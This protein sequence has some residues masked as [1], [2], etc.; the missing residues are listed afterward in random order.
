MAEPTATD[1]Q[2]REALNTGTKPVAESHRFNEAD[3]AAWMSDHV[4]GFAGPLEVRQFKGGQSNPTY[5]LTTPGQK[6]V[7]R[8]K[9]PGKLLPSAH[10]VDREYRVISALHPTGFPVPRPYGLCED[11][12]VIGTMFYIM[13]KVEGRILWDQ[14][15]PAYQPT[16]RHALH[17]AIPLN[18]G[19]G[20]PYQ[21]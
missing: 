11:E 18:T 10:A 9:P 13:D 6:Y 5:E 14:S 12:G 7:M 21:N 2:T 20:S 16:E 3:L 4:E 1:E 17:M 8:R 15:L 19:G